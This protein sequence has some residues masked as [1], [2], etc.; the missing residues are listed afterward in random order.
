MSESSSS[1]EQS[2]LLSSTTNALPGTLS[3]SERAHKIAENLPALIGCTP[4]CYLSTRI[5][6]TK[7]RI[8][9]KMENMEPMMSIK[10][11]VALSMIAAA[12]KDG[13]LKPGGTILEASSGNTTIGL[14]MVGI[15]RGYKVVCCMPCGYSIERRAILSALGAKVYLTPSALGIKG[16]FRMVD[17]L[18]KENP[19][20]W[21]ANQFGN[22][23]NYLA[24]FSTGEEIWNQTHKD[25]GV[26]AF[27]AMAGTSGTF[28]GISKYL[29]ARNDKI[30]CFVG[31]PDESAVLSGEHAGHHHISGTGPGIVAPFLAQNA[32]LYDGI[33]R[34]KTAEAIDMAKKLA[35]TDGLMVG[36][37][38]GANVV[39][40]LK[41][42]AMPGM[43]GKVIVTTV[44]DTGERYM[45]DRMWN[46]VYQAMRTHPVVPVEDLAEE[47]EQQQ[48]QQLLQLPQVAAAVQVKEPLPPLL[49]ASTKS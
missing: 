17:R 5:N 6:T 38:T 4:C 43:A 18:L 11:R 10:D 45:S 15:S 33:I 29:K 20:Y 49:Q 24:H 48:Q 31:E 13:S 44:N 42:A 23:N 30:L 34:V 8:V 9:L 26:D 2:S 36:A 21:F 27:V 22:N 46:D 35:L 28:V 40:A 7:A 19:N 47:Q 12:E 16:L 3:F 25:G 14:A 37:S 41:I 32:S 39:M 1:V